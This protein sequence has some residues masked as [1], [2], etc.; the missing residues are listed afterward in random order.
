MKNWN[1][2]FHGTGGGGFVGGTSNS[3]R[4]PVGRGFVTGATDTG[5]E[6]GS[7]S[8]ALD[9]H[10]HLNW[11]SII[12]NA[13]LG[14]H[15]MTLVGKALTEKLYGKPAKYSYFVGAS[16][17]GRQGL[18]EAQ[19]FPDDYDGIISG[20]PAINWHRFLPADV[21]PE[22]VM[23]NAKNFV[24]KA[25]LDA[26]TAAAIASCDEADGVKDGVIDDPIHCSF[27]PKELVGKKIGDSDFTEA[28][29]DVIRRIWEGP[30]GKGGRFLWYGMERGSD[31][32]ALA[33]TGGSPLS[34]RP[35]GIPV[36]YLKYYLL[37]DPKWDWTTLT[38]ERFELLWEQSVEEFGAVIGTDNPDLTRFRDR[39][40]KILI[41]HGLADQ[42]IPAAGTIDYF[43]RVQK[44]MGGPEKTAEFARLF[45]VPGVDHGF[46]G[47]GPSPTG[48]FEALVRWVE[49]GQAPDQLIGERRDQTGKVIGKR[50]LFAYP[51]IAKYKGSDSTDELE[52]FAPAIGAN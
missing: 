14:I 27:D 25:K 18:S 23:N 4:G 29:A 33:G 8:F 36:D 40:S 44:Q 49:E 10:G 51:K 9:E 20:C 11:Q 1:G 50:P 7:G 5:H 17:G 32:S 37:E 38:V 35:F 13:Y 24:P 15:E 16:T 41:I 26:A 3:L 6:G 45:L 28:D 34:G 39:G 52:N 42:L 47:L 30:R 2:R 19:R 21:W 22:V 31:L 46:R 48:Q 43:K 12:D